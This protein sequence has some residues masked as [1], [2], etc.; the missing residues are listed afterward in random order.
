M[1]HITQYPGVGL[2]IGAVVGILIAH[3]ITKVI[4]TVN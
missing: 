2:I 3:T 1:I 4:A